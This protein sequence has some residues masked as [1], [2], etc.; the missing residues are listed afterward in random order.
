MAQSDADPFIEVHTPQEL[1]EMLA[2]AWGSSTSDLRPDSDDPAEVEIGIGTGDT[3]QFLVRHKSGRYSVIDTHYGVAIK[4]SNPE[5]LMR[6]LETHYPEIS[7]KD[8][9]GGTD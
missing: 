9:Q 6:A 2:R 7:F 3:G 5:A 4:L 1:Q 8:A